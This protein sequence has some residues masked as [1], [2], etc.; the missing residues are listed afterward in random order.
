MSVATSEEDRTT[1]VTALQPERRVPISDDGWH[2]LEVD[3]LT[4]GTLAAMES[5][6]LG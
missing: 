3:M 4:V 5:V 2:T 6:V 1:N